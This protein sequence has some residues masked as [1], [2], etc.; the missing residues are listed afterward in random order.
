MKAQRAKSIINR[1][2]RFDYAIGDELVAGLEL[3]G[4]EV[5]SIRAGHVVLRGSFVNAKDGELWLNNM[6]V[7]P[8]PVNQAALPEQ[9]R[10]RPRKLLVNRRQ[11]TELTERRRQGESILPLQLYTNGRYIKVNL[12]IGRG[13]KKYDKRAVIKQRDTDRETRQIAK[14]R[15]VW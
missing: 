14:T 15:R 3:T 9:M 8:L 2:A 6:Q 12:G 7:N 1:R 4:P 11:L 5:R 10:Q 13:K